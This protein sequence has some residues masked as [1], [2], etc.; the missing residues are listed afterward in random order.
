[1][2]KTAAWPVSAVLNIVADAAGED[3]RNR[4]L[5][6]LPPAPTCL[7]DVLSR[8]DHPPD[9]RSRVGQMTPTA[10]A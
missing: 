2:E 9:W 8:A 4:V 3:L 7:W 1:M 6:Q 10:V 5:L